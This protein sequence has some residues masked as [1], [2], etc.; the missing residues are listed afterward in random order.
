MRSGTYH[1]T[2]FLPHG[3]SRANVSS[4]FCYTWIA[5]TE[6]TCWFLFTNGTSFF[7][8]TVARKTMSCDNDDLGVKGM[9]AASSIVMT[10]LDGPFWYFCR[11]SQATRQTCTRLHSAIHDFGG[12]AGPDYG[13]LK[14]CSA[15]TSWPVALKQCEAKKEETYFLNT[16]EHVK[17]ET[18]PNIK[19]Y[20]SG[21]AKN[22]EKSPKRRTSMNAKIQN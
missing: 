11:T 10:A 9:L 13:V 22:H 16:Q 2:T 8:I 3:C 18:M 20:T 17:H 19:S 1:I 15:E 14:T 7:N 4:R 5:A 21:G 12:Q 6:S